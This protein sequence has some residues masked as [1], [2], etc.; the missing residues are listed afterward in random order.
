VVAPTDVS[1]LEACLLER[2]EH[3]PPTEAWQP[4]QGAA[5]SSST[6]SVSASSGHGIPSLAAASR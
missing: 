5:T 2:T 6:T 3:L 4:A 1:L